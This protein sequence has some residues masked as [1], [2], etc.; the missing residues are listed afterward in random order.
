MK[1]KIT[2]PNVTKIVKIAGKTFTAN[3]SFQILSF[4]RGKLEKFN[5]L[6]HKNQHAN[7]DKNNTPTCTQKGC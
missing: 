5:P 1:T 4:Q 2:E 6:L 3:R 7:S